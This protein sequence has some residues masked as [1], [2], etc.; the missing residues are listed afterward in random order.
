M[1][2]LLPETA[3]AAQ[4]VI[5]T[6]LYHLINQGCLINIEITVLTNLLEVLYAYGINLIAHI[7]LFLHINTQKY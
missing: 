6:G 3:W 5:T 7:F 4:E 1:S 2:K